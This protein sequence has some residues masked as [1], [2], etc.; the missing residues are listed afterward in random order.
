MEVV[1]LRLVNFPARSSG[2]PVCS[3]SFGPFPFPLGYVR[4]RYCVFSP[5]LCVVGVVGSVRSIFRTTC[6][7]HSCAPLW[8]LGSF[9]YV[10]S[11]SVRRRAPFLQFTCALVVVGLVRVR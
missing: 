9:G 5:F 1:S 8:P 4:V 6:T 10:Q 2:C 7:V 3:D 11:I